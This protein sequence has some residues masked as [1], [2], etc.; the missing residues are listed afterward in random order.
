MSKRTVWKTLADKESASLGK[1]N[2]RKKAVVSE[3]RRIENRIKDIDDYILEYTSR[4]KQEVDTEHNLQRLNGKMNM[5]TQ[6]AN[7][8]KELEV[9]QRECQ[10]ALDALTHGIVRHQEELLKYSKIRE[11][12]KE[13]VVYKEKS[14]ESKELDAL[15]IQNFISDM[16]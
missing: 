7:A 11:K 12:Y 4:M 14:N 1:L 3:K 2:E 15:A 13:H 10:Q 5:I 9:I 6:L 16:R 8:R